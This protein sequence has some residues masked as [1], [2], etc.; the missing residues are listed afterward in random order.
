VKW[1]QVKMKIV[2]NNPSVREAYR[3]VVM[4]PG[5]PRAVLGEARDLVHQGWALFS[6]PFHGNMRLLRNPY[7]SLILRDNRGRIDAPSVL[8]IEEACS[9]LRSVRFDHL[10]ES[11]EDYRYLDKDLLDRSF[12]E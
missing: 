2:T 6:H 8:S 10:E 3:D 7:R 1:Y 4:V 12:P 9:R 11:L 5:D